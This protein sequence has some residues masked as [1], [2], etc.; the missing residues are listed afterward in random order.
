[1]C[2][3][4]RGVVLVLRRTAGLMPV[5][6]E[7]RK[8]PKNQTTIEYIWIDGWDIRPCACRVWRVEVPA[9]EDRHVASK[10]DAI[11]RLWRCRTSG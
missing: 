11:G 8:R 7:E 4:W 6:M 5:A 2:F 1:M 10:R 3:K 9:A